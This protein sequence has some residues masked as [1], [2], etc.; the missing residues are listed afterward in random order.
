MLIYNLDHVNYIY[1]NMIIMYT[2]WYKH[3]KYDIFLCLL[4][5]SYKFIFKTVFDIY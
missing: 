3:I 2:S 1:A 4:L 5:L